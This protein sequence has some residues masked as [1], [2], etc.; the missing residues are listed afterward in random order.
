MHL[1]LSLSLPLLFG[2]RT[3]DIFKVWWKVFFGLRTISVGGVL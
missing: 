1:P 3:K 2:R